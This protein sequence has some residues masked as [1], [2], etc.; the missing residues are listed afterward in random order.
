M[1]NNKSFT[2]FAL[3]MY[4]THKFS[5]GIKLVHLQQASNV[6]C[7]GIGINTGARDQTPSQTGMAHFIEHTMFKGTARRTATQIINR[8]EDVGGELNAYTTKE[9][10]FVYATTL[11]RDFERAAELISDMVFN[12][13]FPQKEIT[14]EAEVI[15]EE[16]E[17]YNDTPSELIFDDFEELIFDK[18]TLGIDILGSARKLAK[19]TTDDAAGFVKC[20]YNT[21]QM[22]FF[23]VSPL[24]F[25]KV[26]NVVEKCVGGIPANLRKHTR[27]QNTIY[28]QKDIEKRKRTHQIHLV[29]GNRSCALGSD[30]FYPMY[31]LNN[32]LGGPGMNSRLNLALRE[33]NGL[34]YTVE[35]N[36]TTYTDSGVFCVYVGAEQKNL[37]KCR[38]LISRE[39]EK[40]ATTAITPTALAKY[41]RQTLGQIAIANENKEALALSIAKSFLHRDKIATYEQI[42]EYINEITAENIR[43][44]AEKVFDEQMLSSVLYY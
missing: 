20:N 30:E 39:M 8:L 33:H 41:K 10:T 40:L 18:Q 36:L 2:T 19:Y 34:A 43:K 9:E 21:D 44:A 15:A 6:C 38:K 32:I 37:D 1:I 27:E 22:V 3:V 35:S 26:L 14:R 24:D 29:V 12:A 17:S 11:A 42:C 4:F 25:K 28:T 5:N 31:M 13:T 23:S 7:C 16:I